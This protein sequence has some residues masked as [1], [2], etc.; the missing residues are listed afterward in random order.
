VA[1]LDAEGLGGIERSGLGNQQ[2]GK[3]GVNAPVADLIGVGQSVAGDGPA[4]AQLVK[5]G[6]GRAQAGLN[7]AQALA[8]GELSEGHA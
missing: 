7:I 8:L 4:N 3:V 1:E 6:R 5:P 2:L